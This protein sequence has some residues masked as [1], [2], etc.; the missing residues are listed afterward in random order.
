LRGD[1]FNTEEFNDI[2]A[3]GSSYTKD[4]QLTG[5]DAMVLSPTSI[6]ESRFQGST[7][8]AVSNAGDH[9]GPEVD[10]VGVARFGRPFDADTGRREDRVQFVDNITVE[11]GHHELKTGITINHVK[12]RSEMR[13]GFAGLFTFR[14]VDDFVAGR[15]AEWRQ[16]FGT[17]RTGLGVTSFGAFIQDRYQPVGGLTLNLGVRYDIERLPESFRTDFRNLSPRIGLAWNPSSEWI[18]RSGFGMYY[19]RVPLAFL[20]RS[21]EKDGIHA[22]EQVADDT[23]APTIFSTSGGHVASPFA[24][25]APSIF[26]ADPA[27]VTPYSAQANASVERLISKDVTMRA[28]Y[29]FTRG[30]HLLRT[31]NINLP[32]PPPDPAGRT[33]FGRGRI[34]SRFDAIYRLESS[35]ASTYHGLTVSLNKRLSDEFELLASYTRSK[36]IDDASDFDEQPENPYNLRAERALSR[37]D[38]RN[39]FV[40]SSLF[41]L[42]IGEDENDRGKSKTQQDL[43]GKLFG[44]IEAA[45]IF[46]FSSGRPVNVLTGIDEERSRAY[47]FASR[48]LGLGRDTLR[49]P[50]FVNV[51]LRIV[52]Y[53]RY[54]ERRR[55]DFVTEAFNLLNHPNVLALNPFYGSGTTPQRSFG[56]VT[57]FAAPRQIRFS[58]DFEF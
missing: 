35:A 8:R 36:A 18:V 22:F 38:A 40:V 56:T 9:I 7:R 42:P 31:R 26:A 51:D 44:H 58:I 52:K 3:R 27:F 30:I 54:G 32:P 14:T 10:I 43:V 19:D 28:D 47:P 45:P 4:Y 50:H 49:T 16:A 39:R 20:N 2:S 11:R 12:L 6:N 48:P 1:A 5:S 41:D 55:L 57:G 53:I 46:T 37:Q 15:A 23:V 34:D 17:A 24:A 29:L 25:I 33:I 13:D 21:I